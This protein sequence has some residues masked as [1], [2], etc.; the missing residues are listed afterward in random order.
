M[1]GKMRADGVDGELGMAGTKVICASIIQ[2]ERCC[3]QYAVSDFRHDDRSA[4]L[5]HPKQDWPCSND[6]QVRRVR[7][8][9]SWFVE[10][11]SA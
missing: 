11:E 7:I 1:V 6:N 9:D 5:I 3:V 2:C 8:P 4:L 10:L